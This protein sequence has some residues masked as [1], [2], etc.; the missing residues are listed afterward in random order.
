MRKLSKILIGGGALLLAIALLW[1]PLVVPRL[2]KLPADVD[3]TD[4]YAGTFVTF[5]DAATG[6]T[7]ATPIEE[8]LT[9]DRH[10]AT[11]PGE[12]GAG[13]T[14]L[15]ET[16]T[17]RMGDRTVVQQSR[18]AVDRRTMENVADDRAWTFEPGNVVDRSGTYYVTLP[19]GLDSSGETFRI[20]KPEAGTSYQVTS[21]EPATGTAGGASVVNLR[22]NIPTPLPVADYELANLQAQGLPMALTPEQ[23]AARLAAAGID[24]NALAPILAQVLTPEELAGV[25]AAMAEPV[26]LQY[27]V[28]GHGLLAAE[29]RTGGLVAL[30][31]I[32][33]GVSVQPDL[34]GIEPTLTALRPH[35]D[36]PEVAALVTALEGMAAAAPQPV[37]ELR[38]T[39]TPAS[40]DA[41]G[42]YA[43]DQSDK[44]LLA[45]RTLPRS[46]ATAGVLL[47]VV[48]TVL[49][50]RT[51]RPQADALV[52]AHPATTIRPAA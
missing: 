41:A 5:L 9:V 49:F 12:T 4:R 31:D 37:Y 50:R 6:E 28:Y 42:A 8:P 35:T 33:D 20:W 52:I 40:V 46:A 44:V 29:H 18:Y 51:R 13:V 15:E 34:S 26:P 22:G 30:S 36:V 32:V 24:T 47:L 16:A 25:A 1:T 39:Q 27:F 3:R 7:L 23:S 2:V 19:M 43:A 21:T 38:Y 11:V 10:V 48:G 45:T 14:L 17:V